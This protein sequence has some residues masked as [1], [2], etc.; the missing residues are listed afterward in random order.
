MPIVGYM[1]WRLAVEL[2]FSTF[3]I[4][5][6]YLIND[7]RRRGNSGPGV[8]LLLSRLLQLFVV[9]YVRWPFSEDPVDPEPRRTSGHWD[10]SMWPHH[11]SAA[12]IALAFCSSTSWR[13]HCMSGA[14]VAG[15]SD[16]CIPS[17]RHPTW[18]NTDRRPLRSAAVRTCF[19]PQTHNSFRDQSFSAAG[20]RVWNSLPPHLSQDMNFARFKHTLKTFLF[21]C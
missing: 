4:T 6:S 16:T 17:W 19:V 5:S 20:L 7:H 11:A 12:S 15:G 21:G 14:P 3:A 18:T 13:Q 8:H 10:P 1:H 9:R 2:D